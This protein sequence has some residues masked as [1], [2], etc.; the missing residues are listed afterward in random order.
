MADY[1]GMDN[2]DLGDYDEVG[3][4]EADYNEAAGDDEVEGIV[5][6]AVVRGLETLRKS[7]AVEC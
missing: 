5:C 6:Y 2:A 3:E 1:D 4:G 7:R